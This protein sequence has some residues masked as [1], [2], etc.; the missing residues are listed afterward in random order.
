[1]SIYLGG[2]IMSEQ[3]PHRVSISLDADIYKWYRSLGPRSKALL[4]NEYLRRGVSTF[5]SDHETALQRHERLE[6]EL[7]TMQMGMVTIYNAMDATAA[8][9]RDL[10]EQIQVQRAMID[11]AIERGLI[12]QP[13]LAELLQSEPHQTPKLQEQSEA[14]EPSSPECT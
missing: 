10:K 7:S 9:I 8:E 1:M 14:Q 2:V 4:I 6:L 11:L 13:E 3:R 5:G 12:S